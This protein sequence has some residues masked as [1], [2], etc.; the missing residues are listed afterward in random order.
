MDAQLF[1]DVSR[2]VMASFILRDSHPALSQGSDITKKTSQL[3]SIRRIA[4]P[5][6]HLLSN[7]LLL[8]I[9]D[10]MHVLATCTNDIV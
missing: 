8:G 4:L 3:V 6:H 5:P 7:F 9:V 10:S 1:Y 2:V